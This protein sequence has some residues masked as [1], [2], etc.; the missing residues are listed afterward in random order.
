[1]SLDVS[2][3]WRASA[4]QSKDVRAL[5][6]LYYGNEDS[7]LNL[8]THDMQHDGVEYKG[9]LIDSPQAD[10][11][12]KMYTHKISS[13][14]TSLNVNN[15]EY[16]PGKRFSDLVESVGAGSDIGFY[17]RYYEIRLWVQGVTAWAGLPY[18]SAGKVIDVVQK[19]DSFEL[20]LQEFMRTKFVD[21][22]DTLVADSDA[23]DTTI[24]LPEG[25]AGK[26]W[27]NI[28]GSH[29][30]H[31][32]DN[33][34]ALETFSN[35]NNL[36]PMLD[37]NET[38]SGVRHWGVDEHAVNEINRESD[39][40][41]QQQIWG[42]DDILNRFVR[43]STEFTVLVNTDADGCKISVPADA[44]FIDYVYP[45]A[46]GTVTL[47]D[48]GDTEPP[49]YQWD[50][51]GNFIDRDFTT[52]AGDVGGS[53]ARAALTDG[54]TTPNFVKMSVPFTAYDNQALLDADIDSIKNYYYG[55]MTFSNGGVSSDFRLNVESPIGTNPIDADIR[56]GATQSGSGGTLAG[57]ALD[58]EYRFAKTGS[59]ASTDEAQLEMYGC[60]KG[61]FYHP[62]RILPLFFGGKGRKY[63][64][65]I[66]NRA[67]TE[68]Y[69]ETHVDNDNSGAMVENPVGGIEV[70]VRNHAN[71]AP[72]TL[73]HLN[74]TDFATHAKWDAAGDWD[75]TGGNLEFTY[76]GTPGTHDAEQTAVNR[77]LLGDNSR[78]Y[79]FTYTVSVTTAPDGN[80]ALS[81]INF[82]GS[83]I[84]LPFTVG[85]HTV[86]FLS[87]ADATI[88]DFTFRAFYTVTTQ[89]QFALDDVSLVVDGINA[90]T[91][92]I[93]SNDIS[94]W[95]H[96]F[97]LIRPID[98]PKLL[99][100]IEQSSR[101]FTWQQPNGGMKCK[102]LE[103]TYSAS[104]RT[105][106]LDRA[107]SI[108]FSRSPVKDI[109]TK[110]EVWYNH[111]GQNYKSITASSEDATQQTKYNL[112]AAESYLKFKSKY[113]HDSA[114]ADLLE[115]YLLAQWKQPH[116]LFEGTLGI[117]H[118]DIDFGDIVE[119]SNPPFNVMGE[120]I[121]ANA[122]RAGQTIYKYWW[123]YFV[124]R[125]IDGIK[126]KAFQLHDLS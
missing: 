88:Q 23:A 20:I 81:L 12:G 68:G 103:D 28:Y 21:V 79:I 67:T 114:T 99:Q 42:F 92:N 52:K 118:L 51:E 62:N 83:S 110:V 19:E 35:I 112:T 31:K 105:I 45:D 38:A 124:R 109:S 101:S 18:F 61:V 3:A 8:S 1:M 93:A 76:S 6:R 122:T 87:A 113:I 65:E 49:E 10:I 102:I 111:D 36:V 26:V 30:Y 107:E 16:T 115:A 37:L 25:T 54:S 50:N 78:S 125:R 117:D 41:E 82:P 89:G 94:A 64:T 22:A 34:R 46:D 69:S 39:D 120:D 32:G 80:F 74:E 59:A 9:L 40:S 121:S 57:I 27:P 70:L 86:N 75:D 108:S 66:D 4:R 33:S 85:T 116:N 90:D 84:S 119:F 96:S 44:V 55:L 91:F 58:V 123:V 29:I 98:L 48:S 17:N 126:I 47:S 13:G 5:V 7:Y 2:L 77:A 106:D 63:G 11:S 72:N 104:D 97:A 15:L 53:P 56:Y 100:E 60:Y 43:L 14:V 95:L 24:G 71:Y 73:E